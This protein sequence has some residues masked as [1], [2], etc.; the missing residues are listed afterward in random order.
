MG[1]KCDYFWMVDPTFTLRPKF[2]YEL[3]EALRK[4]CPGIK[5]YCETRA[6]CS[7][8]LLNEMAKAG[9]I[10]VD[11][12]LES[13]SPK[14][15]KAIRKDLDVSAIV[16]VTKQCKKLGMRVLVFIMYSLPEET[17]DDF[18]K[19]M[20]VLRK[21]KPYIYTISVNHTLILPGT[22]LERQAKSM[23]L[24]P[25]GFSWYDANFEGIPTWK[26]LMSD[27]EITKCRKTLENYR[28]ALHHSKIMYIKKRS[29]ETFIAPLGQNETVIRAIRKFPVIHEF[30]RSSV[31]W[32][33]GS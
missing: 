14:V 27:E 15:L 16:E 11:F 3:C 23:N 31:R 32:I 2:A 19:T 24:L 18:L 9:C 22:Q 1:F 30:L 21:I 33:F 5:W 10:S 20:D 29:K 28:Y 17:Y 7:L 8:A 13:G 26:T 12:G 6:D 4:H 25:E